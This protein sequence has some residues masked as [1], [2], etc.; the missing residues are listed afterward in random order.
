MVKVPGETPGAGPIRPLNSPAPVEVVE[1]EH[2]RPIALTTR[3]RRQEITSIDDLWEMS[4]EWWRPRP[5][6]R[7]YYEVTTGD[8]RRLT[9]FRDLVDG[10][11]YR[12][13]A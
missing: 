7:R 12:Q 13:R 3:G 4:D 6:A 11:W 2:R 5:T 8:G 10:A 1:D 9:L